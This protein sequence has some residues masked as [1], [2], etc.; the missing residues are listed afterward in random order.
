M[1]YTLDCLRFF[2]LDNQFV[3]VFS[4]NPFVCFKVIDSAP[5][6]HQFSLVVTVITCVAVPQLDFAADTGTE[7]SENIVVSSVAITTIAEA[8]FLIFV[9]I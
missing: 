6:I 5:G 8:V 2:F 9:I 4:H 7:K 3:V 1:A